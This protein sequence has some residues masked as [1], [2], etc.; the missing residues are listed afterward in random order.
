MQRREFVT[1]IGG[2]A[3]TWPLATRAQQSALPTIGY[4]STRSPGEAKYVTDAF[5][6]GLNEIGYVE[7]RNLAIEF[8]WA[9]LQYDQLPTL[10]SDLVR[11][12]VVVIA[13][14]GG[15]HSGLAAK[16]ATSTIPIVFVSAGDPVTFGLVASL[17]RPGA[18][19]TGVTSM[20]TELEAKRLGLLRELVQGAARFA[21]LVDPTGPGTAESVTVGRMAAAAMGR[22]VEFLNAS[23]NREIDAAFA[24]LAQ[25]RIDALQVSNFPL[26]QNRRVQI[27]TLAVRHAVPVIYS[28]REFADVGGLMSYGTSLTDLRR[29]VAAYTARILNGEKP[30]DLPVM[31]PT[32]F[33]FVINMQTARLIGIDVPPT[34]LALADEVIE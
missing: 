23:T 31:Q 9:E 13:A 19:V 12:Q 24:S 7:G 2:A 6:Q 26:F 27:V 30:A 34:L 16:A 5:I 3:A 33:E 4:L 29:R 8:R 14:V 21:V 15:I 32:K 28:T 22:Q 10:A 17:N 11:R 18:N 25:N 1:L 20:N